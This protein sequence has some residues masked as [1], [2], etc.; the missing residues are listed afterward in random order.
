MRWD[1]KVC[2]ITGGA[3]GIGRC[4][5][6]TF[7]ALGTQVA[8]IDRNQEAGQALCQQLGQEGG[9]PFFFHG[10]VGRK[11]DL[12]AFSDQIRER[13]GRVDV[14]INNACISKGGLLS[15]CDYEDFNEV[16]R[17][18]VTAPYWLVQ[19]L[20]PIFAPGASIVNM[21]S[22]RAFQSQADT[23]S[24]TAAKGGIAA[25]THA[26]AISLA[27]RVRVNAVAPGWIDTG[28]TYQ[29]GYEPSY[30]AEDIEQHP[31][32]RVGAPEDISR[33]ILFLCDE[34]N[35]FVNGQAFTIDGGM[36]VRMIYAGDEGWSLNPSI[37]H[38]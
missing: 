26:M 31:S 4:L 33:A 37:S 30:T 23:E 9:E 14:L 11:Q 38:Q 15:G 22:T 19:R 28:G 2:V 36:S 3:L 16:L 27:G 13:F 1:E 32:K 34:Q 6:Q 8:F 18:G 29:E 25:L 21:T 10:D 20:L 7:A 24:Y 17:I 5:T 12:D 35:S